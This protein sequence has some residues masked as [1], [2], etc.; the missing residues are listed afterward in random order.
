MR[1]SKC[2]RKFHYPWGARDVGSICRRQ[3]RV[4]RVETNDPF[5]GD[6]QTVD[7]GTY[8]ADNTLSYD[9]VGTPYVKSG[10]RSAERLRR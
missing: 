10:R 5:Y 8:A 4:S 3:Y 1:I 6:G 7:G 2:V 9:H